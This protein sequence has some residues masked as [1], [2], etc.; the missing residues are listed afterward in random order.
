[1]VK[2]VEFGAFVNLLGKK[3]GLVHISELTDGHVKQTTDVVNE[4]DAVK[5]KVLDIDRS[6]K[7]KLTMKIKDGET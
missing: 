4:G 5:V 1:M 2:C 7:I 3:D 6:G